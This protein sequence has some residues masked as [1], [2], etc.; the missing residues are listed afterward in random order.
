MP[1]GELQGRIRGAKVAPWVRCRELTEEVI[2]FWARVMRDEEEQTPM[3]V[4]ASE[5]IMER[6]WGKAPILIAGDDERPILVDVRN[7]DSD[8]I[9]VLE[10]ALIAAL[11][12]GVS[13]HLNETAQE[14]AQAG[15]TIEGSLVSSGSDL[16][17]SEQPRGLPDYAAPANYPQT[18]EQTE[19]AMLTNHEQC[20]NHGLFSGATHGGEGDA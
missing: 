6:G 1:K 15:A 12:E 4:R 13:A 17:A 3:R 11:G 10:S 16:P 8:R 14:R 19:G 2:Q 18:E 7:M 9:K 5:N 20:L